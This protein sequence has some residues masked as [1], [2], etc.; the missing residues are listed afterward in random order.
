[1][2]KIKTITPREILDSRGNPT[3]EVEI[4]LNSGIKEIASVP[5]GAST[6]TLEALELRDNDLNRY[7]GKGILNAIKNINNKISSSIIDEVSGNQSRIDNIMIEL[8]G[9]N[10]KRNLGANSILAVSLAYAKASAKERNLELYEYLYLSEQNNDIEM[11]MPLINVING[12][13]HADNNLDI[14]EFMIVP[15]GANT[16]RDAMQ[17]S[18]EVIYCLKKVLKGMNLN[19]NVGDEGGFAPNLRSNE[20]AIEIIIKSINKAGFSVK[21]DFAIALD[22]ASNELY[23]NGKY[24]VDKKF[25]TYKEF[26]EYQS[27]LV[28][29]YPIIS[30]EDGMQEAD[31]DGWKFLTKILGKKIQ[32]V[33]DDLFVTNLELLK[34]GY[35][36]NMANSILIK[37]NQIGTLTETLNTINFA[38]K[39]G[40]NFIISHRS[41]ETEDTFISD[42]SVA[43]SS[44]QIKTGSICRTDRTS[45]YN[46]LLRIEEYES[47]NGIKLSK[48]IFN[49]YNDKNE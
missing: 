12:G 40:F 1:M 45:K 19:T 24:I 20:E 3:I 7:N 16:F 43:V 32:L 9:T 29:N 25:L 37:P 38:K 46:R 39:I 15:V 30:I 48:K 23:N 47:G 26:A 8:D 28:N 21:K 14:Q 31:F 18:S 27:N 17:Y 35:K 41:G 49:K 2:S 42:L 44:G 4:E 11:P 33:G 34:S 6:G 10:N 22:I 13:A 36:E 5:S